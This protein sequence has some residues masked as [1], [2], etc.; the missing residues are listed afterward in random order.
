MAAWRGGEFGGNGSMYMYGWVPSLFTWNYH[1]SVNQL[2]SEVKWSCSV[3]SNSARPHR[4]QPTRLPC[5]W[6]SLGRNTGVGC[7]FLLQCMKVKSESEVAQS[8]PTLSNPMDCSPPGSLSIG[9]S[10]QEYWRGMPLPSHFWEKCKNTQIHMYTGTHV[11]FILNYSKLK[12]LAIHLLV[13]HHG[14]SMGR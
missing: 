10:R 3:M 11:K 8:C 7:R 1:N 6:D 14:H 12:Y 13:V 4:R 5:P 2:W 9:F